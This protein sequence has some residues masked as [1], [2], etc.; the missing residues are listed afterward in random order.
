MNTS[1]SATKGEDQNPLGQ[2]RIPRNSRTGEGRPEPARYFSAG[3]LTPRRWMSYYHQIKEV[4][5]RADR[6]SSILEVGPGSQIGAVFYR[7]LARNYV[8]IDIEW[9]LQPDVVGTVRH[10]PFKDNSFDIVACFEVL[11]H[12]PFADLDHCLGELNRV[13]SRY[14]ILS[15]PDAGYYLRLSVYLNLIHRIDLLKLKVRPFWAKHK[16]GEHYWELGKKGLSVKTMRRIIGRW[17]DPV[18]EFVPSENMY[19]HFWVLV[20]RGRGSLAP[21]KRIQDSRR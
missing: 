15:L 21:L 11:E 20:P 6:G 4:T 9:E 3:Y 17:F 12:L 2:L 16:K 10:L 8:S 13:A 1:R 18:R 14:V 19:H 7:R 5:S